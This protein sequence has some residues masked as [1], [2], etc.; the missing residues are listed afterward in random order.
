MNKRYIILASGYYFY[1]FNSERKTLHTKGENSIKELIREEY[2]FITSTPNK[3]LFYG[4]E[5]IYSK[6]GRDED[7]VL[8]GY[9]KENLPHKEA[10]KDFIKNYPEV[11][12]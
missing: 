10:I 12:I 11:L 8:I 1:C 5:P 9:V 4:N 6:S 2:K 3:Y 7:I